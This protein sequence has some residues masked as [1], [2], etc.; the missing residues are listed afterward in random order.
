MKTYYNTNNET[1]QTLETSKKKASYQANVILDF[2]NR[3]AGQ[4]YTPCE[5]LT[6]CFPK[7]PHF[8]EGTPITSVRRTMTT[9]TKRGYLEKQSKDKM[10]LGYQGR[11][12][13]TWK[14]NNN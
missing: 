9:L 10:K 1:G 13:H 2:F 7:H 12:V 8:N 4:N 5:V 14:L 11:M 6:F 3:N